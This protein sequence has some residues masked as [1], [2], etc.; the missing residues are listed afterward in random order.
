M[1]TI[2]L[3]RTVAASVVLLVGLVAGCASVAVTSDAIEKNT[4]FALG[5][6]KGTF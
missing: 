5:L 4:A 3:R 6:E 1:K 2:Y